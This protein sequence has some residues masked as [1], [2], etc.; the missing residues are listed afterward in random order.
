MLYSCCICTWSNYCNWMLHNSLTHVDDLGSTIEGAKASVDR[1]LESKRYYLCN[2][3]SVP[4]LNVT[5]RNSMNEKQN[6][7]FC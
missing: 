5:V 3:S 1:L 2:K 7:F 4:G 6:V